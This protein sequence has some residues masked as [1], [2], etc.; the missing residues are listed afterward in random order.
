MWRLASARDSKLAAL[1]HLKGITEQG[2]K[3]WYMSLMLNRLM[4]VYF[5]Q[6]KGIL[7]GDP[8]YL[9]SRLKQVQQRQG[10]GKFLIFYRYFLLRLFHEG[11][12]KQPAQRARDLEQLLGVIPYFNGGL[13]EMHM[14]EQKHIGIDIPDEAFER[15][16]AFFDQDDWH[17]DTCPLS[18]GREINPDVLGYIFEKYINRKQIGAHYTKED[19]TES[20]A[21]NTII[22]YLF[23]A[24]ERKCAIAFQ[25]NSAVWQLLRDDRARGPQGETRR[26]TLSRASDQSSPV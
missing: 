2:D 8:D 1:I 5:I 9:K 14:L 17:L 13:F 6:R 15:L 19:M 21:K 20:I 12:A 18:N 22:P 16:F 4:F 7:D 10:K 23:N 26:R 3:E 24:A 25:P 11:F